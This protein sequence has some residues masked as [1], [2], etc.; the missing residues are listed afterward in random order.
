MVIALL[1]SACGGARG[2][3]PNKP[4]Q[5]TN[6]FTAGGGGDLVARI[7]AAYLSKKWGQPINVVDKPG[8]SGVPGTMEVLSA[9]ADG[10]NVLLWP[11]LSNILTAA[12]ADTPYK[13]DQPTPLAQFTANVIVFLV[14]ADSPFKTMKDALDAVKQN[15]S[16]YSF[17]LAGLASPPLVAMSKVFTDAGIDPTKP[18]RVIFDGEAP[19]FTAT[20]GGQVAFTPAYISGA[21]PLIQAGKLRGLAVSLPTRSRFLP[22]VPTGAEAGYPS[23]DILS[24]NGFAGP[25][26]LPDDVVKKWA[27]GLKEASQ[28]PDVMKQ[29]E[30]VGADI[31]YLP[32]TEFKQ[33]WGNEYNLADKIFTAAG[34][35]Q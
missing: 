25:P 1:V 24:W 20:I 12:Q 15:P 31:A 5:I 29:V 26:G 9:P 17:G 27:D 11:S 2:A 10:Y 21:L 22:D 28:D 4:I 19:A 34:L 33:R 18:K 6:A 13:W 14:P 23:F 35:K 32:P 3:Y 7:A 16:N 8:G 30:G